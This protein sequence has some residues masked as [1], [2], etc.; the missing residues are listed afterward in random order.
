MLQVLHKIKTRPKIYIKY[1]GYFY[2]NLVILFFYKAKADKS[3]TV[4]M[5]IFVTF[6]CPITKKQP[7]I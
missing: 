1:L 4:F 7:N 5:S 3:L 2:D 6:S